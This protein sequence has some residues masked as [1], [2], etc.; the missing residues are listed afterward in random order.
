[1]KGNQLWTIDRAEIIDE[2]SI[3]WIRSSKDINSKICGSA[4]SE[5]IKVSTIDQTLRIALW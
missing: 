4:I 1:M 2:I 3:F 5:K